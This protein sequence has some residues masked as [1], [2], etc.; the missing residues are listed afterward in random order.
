[1][2]HCR[3]NCRSRTRH[4]LVRLRQR[5]VDRGT[6]HGVGLHRQATQ[7][8]LT[9]LL[10]LSGREFLRSMT[11]RAVRRA[12][13][14]RI[15][16]ATKPNSGTVSVPAGSSDA[17]PQCGQSG[18]KI[19]ERLPEASTPL[20]DAVLKLLQVAARH[21]V[22]PRD[23]H[24]NP[25]ATNVASGVILMNGLREVTGEV[26]LGTGG[27]PCV[28]CTCVLRSPLGIHT[29][30]RHFGWPRIQEGRASSASPPTLL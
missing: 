6:P 4:D 15:L 23:V 20:A 9:D 12:W 13:F 22:D 3:T 19:C 25:P 10:R 29:S 27:V 5:R 24:C 16:A 30:A 18:S 11:R 17:S 28:G 21:S 26:E 14:L 1:M 7:L 2:P 8:A